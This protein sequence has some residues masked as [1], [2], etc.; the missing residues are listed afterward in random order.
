MAREKVAVVM[1]AAW[2][3]ISA[4]LKRPE[5]ERE[6]CSILAGRREPNLIEVQ[7]AL[8]VTNQQRG[9]NAFS[10]AATDWRETENLTPWPL[11]GCFH[12]H[13][14]SAEASASDRRS[15]LRSGLFFLIGSAPFGEGPQLRGFLAEGSIIR[16]WEVRFK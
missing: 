2:Q 15:I 9:K 8:A 1:P 16:S 3:T 11:I 7:A 12:T 5:G 4:Q 13:V 14:R 10:I 6:A